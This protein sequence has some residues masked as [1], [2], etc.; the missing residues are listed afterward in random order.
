M[1][2]KWGEDDIF[3]KMGKHN[4]Q[5]FLNIFR[6]K[7][8]H[9]LQIV[10]NK[11]SIIDYSGETYWVELK[12]RN[13]YFKQFNET[14]FGANK[15]REGF[16]KVD[17]GLRVIYAFAFKDGLY[18]WE[19]TRVSYE[20]VGGD[21]C[22]RMGGTTNRGYND[23]KLHFYLNIVFLTKIS[24]VGADIPSNSLVGKCFITLKK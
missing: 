5:K 24:D 7:I 17:F 10:E 12:S 8:D 4:E 1:F 19:L 14:M 13:C 18:I 21:T 9:T 11:T 23:F 2:K 15:I 20:E 16:R 6:E 3:Y 22:I